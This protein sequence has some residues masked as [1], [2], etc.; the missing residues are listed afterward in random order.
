MTIELRPEDEALIRQRLEAGDGAS[1]EEVVH[2]AL[3]LWVSS[4]HQSPRPPQR[5]RTL[6]EFLLD[7]P[8]AGSELNLERDRDPGRTVEL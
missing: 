5:K 2:R 1:I 4:E 8:L 7:S 3:V 6:S